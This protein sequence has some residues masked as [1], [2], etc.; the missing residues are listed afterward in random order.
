MPGIV[1]VAWHTS[2][3][4]K[5]KNPCPHGAYILVVFDT[6][7]SL[8][9]LTY[10]STTDWRDLTTEVYFPYSSGGKNVQNEGSAEFVSF[11]GP[12]EGAMP[13]CLLDL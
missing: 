1:L 9:K 4:K 6:C 10:Q 11:K 2:T 7:I 5:H 3:N 13:A 8:L 12:E